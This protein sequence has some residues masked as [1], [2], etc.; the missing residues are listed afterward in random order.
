MRGRNHH[1]AAFATR[2]ASGGVKGGIIHGKTDDYA[3]S[4]VENP[5]HVHDL[6]ATILHLFGSIT[7]SSRSVTAGGISGLRMF[8][9]KW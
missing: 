9:A 7:R 1:D 3:N 8:P 4:I 5:V 6:H 2:L